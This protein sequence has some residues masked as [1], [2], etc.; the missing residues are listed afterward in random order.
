MDLLLGL[1]VLLCIAIVII[2]IV[3]TLTRKGRK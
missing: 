2:A 1:F 3:E